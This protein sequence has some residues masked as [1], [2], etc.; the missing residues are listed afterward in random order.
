MLLSEVTSNVPLD[1]TVLRA[2]NVVLILPRDIY[3]IVHSRTEGLNSESNDSFRAQTDKR[4]H[5]AHSP[6]TL[7][8][9]AKL[10]LLDKK[11][12]NII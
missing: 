4:H 8:P 1:T 5:L 12:M 7:I 10:D 11:M 6:L 3:R 2:M 9:K